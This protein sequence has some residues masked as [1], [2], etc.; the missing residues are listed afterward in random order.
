[1]ARY[2]VRLLAVALALPSPATGAFAAA[3]KQVALPNFVV[4]V[5]LSPKADAKF[6]ETGETE[7]IAVQYF[8]KVV[9]EKDG[10]SKGE[11]ELGKEEA[12]IKGASA[13]EFGK[14]TLKS[15]D[16]EKVYGR[17]ATVRIAVTG[18]GKILSGGALDCTSYEQ[19][20][21]AAAGKRIAISCKLPGE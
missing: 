13:A 16:L 3:A 14:I 19:S 17:A 4:A 5:S 18:N 10:D 15:T 8:G 1:M 9:N 2:H 20:I 6:A 12:D 21:S 7:H 11:F